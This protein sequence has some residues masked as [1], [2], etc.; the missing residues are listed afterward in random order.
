MA[1]KFLE[2]PKPFYLHSIVFKVCMVSKRKTQCW[3]GV[4]YFGYPASM[5][6]MDGDTTPY[7]GKPLY[8]VDDLDA[9]LRAGELIVKAIMTK[10]LFV[11]SDKLL[12]QALAHIF[13]SMHEASIPKEDWVEWLCFVINKI[14]LGQPVQLNSRNRPKKLHRG[15]AGVAKSSGLSRAEFTATLPSGLTSKDVTLLWRAH[16]RE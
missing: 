16:K 13:A 15:P 12:N 8:T 1:A 9:D 6:W 2:P 3:P 11:V 14:P 10:E 5:F 4:C 7:D